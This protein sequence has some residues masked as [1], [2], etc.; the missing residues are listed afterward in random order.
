MVRQNPDWFLV[1]PAKA[2]CLEVSDESTQRR[3]FANEAAVASPFD[4]VDIDVNLANAESRGK[5]TAPVYSRDGSNAT[6][7]KKRK[8]RVIEPVP[9]RYQDWQRTAPEELR[10]SLSA[11]G[12]VNAHVVT[13]A[14]GRKF[15]LP[16]AHR[17][18]R[19]TPTVLKDSNTR[20]RRPQ[21]IRK[22]RFCL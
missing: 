2:P 22:L 17:I 6:S 19:M 11:C 4:Q 16:P 9:R 13:G 18:V 3:F 5:A 8:V 15:T 20:S 1:S 7:R 10:Q 21:P 14:L 12:K